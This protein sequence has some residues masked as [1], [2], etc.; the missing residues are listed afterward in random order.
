MEIKTSSY[1]YFLN[2]TFFSF[3]SVPSHIYKTKDIV[4]G[5][6]WNGHR[7]EEKFEGSCGDAYS[8]W[9]IGGSFVSWYF[10]QLCDVSC[11]YKPYIIMSYPLNQGT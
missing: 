2:P 6:Y 1:K 4:I 10:Q 11:T 8:A 3:S 5:G 7:D 9:L